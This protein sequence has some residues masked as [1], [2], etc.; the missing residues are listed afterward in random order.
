MKSLI[1]IILLVFY[2]AFSLGVQV[3]KHY[4]MGKLSKVSFFMSKATC[5]CGK[6]SKPIKCCQ[7]EI[8]TFQI[9]D[10]QQKI[11]FS[12]D[13]APKTFAD[14]F[15]VIPFHTD[16]SFQKYWR[17]ASTNLESFHDYSPHFVPKQPFY[18]LHCNL[19]I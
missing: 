11:A 9:D 15:A 18:L 19:R 5:A 6:P 16:F 7:D 3:N 2:T 12:F 14:C 13:F 8:Q 17:S 1:A 10:E 4:C